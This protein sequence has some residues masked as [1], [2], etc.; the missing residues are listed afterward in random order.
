MLN[1]LVPIEVEQHRAKTVS[2]MGTL[3]AAEMGSDVEAPLRQVCPMCPPICGCL[4]C[5]YPSQVEHRV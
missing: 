3:G 2:R 4:E 5:R 1:T